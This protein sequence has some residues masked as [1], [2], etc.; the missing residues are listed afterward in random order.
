MAV[1]F[2]FVLE[3]M[4]EYFLLIVQIDFV[5]L[6]EGMQYF[7]CVYI[8]GIVLVDEEVGVF[9]GFQGVGMVVDVQNFCQIVCQFGYSLFVVQFIIY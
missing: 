5:F 4:V 1:L 2:V 8:K 7:V 9:V 3:F 6:N